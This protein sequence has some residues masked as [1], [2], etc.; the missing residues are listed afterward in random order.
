[1]CRVFVARAALI[2][3]GA[4]LAATSP[5]LRA[6]PISDSKA[7]LVKRP[8][9]TTGSARL[10]PFPARFGRARAA[11]RNSAFTTG[12]PCQTFRERGET[13]AI[14]LREEMFRVVRFTGNY[15]RPGF[16]WG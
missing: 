6:F 12:S 2:T 13:L 3:A 1:M 4:K 7:A 10:R 9:G 8:A 16:D 11:C 14:E 15:I 5:R